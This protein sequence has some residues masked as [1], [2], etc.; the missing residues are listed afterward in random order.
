V[1]WKESDRA[2]GGKEL[3]QC[4]RNDQTE[5]RKEDKVKE[6]NSKEGFITAYLFSSSVLFL[7]LCCLLL[8]G[9]LFSSF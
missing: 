5:R 9:F 1:I 6:I 2:I 3:F 8:F 4:E 7:F